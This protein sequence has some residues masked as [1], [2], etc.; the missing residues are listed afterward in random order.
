VAVIAVVAVVGGVVGWTQ[1]TDDRTTVVAG[2]G[3]DGDAPTPLTAQLLPSDTVGATLESVFGLPTPGEEPRPF[4]TRRMVQLW[5]RGGTP[6]FGIETGGLVSAVAGSDDHSEH[7]HLPGWV[8]ATYTERADGARQLVLNAGTRAVG[9]ASRELSRDQLLA[10]APAVAPRTTGLGADV[11]PGALPNDYEPLGEAETPTA[12]PLRLSYAKRTDPLRSLTVLY[13]S[14]TALGQ[15]YDRLLDP[16][17]ATEPIGEIPGDVRDERIRATVRFMA[18]DGVEVEVDVSASAP[19]NVALALAVARSFRPVDAE[20]WQRALA[21]I[22]PPD[23]ASVGEAA[24]T[25]AATAVPL[26]TGAGPTTTSAPAP[27]VELGSVL[28]RLTLPDGFSPFGEV[29]T[30]GAAGQALVHQSQTF[31][32]TDGRYLVVAVL[33]GRTAQ[34]L[35]ELDAP[36]PA[37]VQDLATAIGP[38]VRIDLGAVAPDT[39]QLGR[40]TGPATAVTMT[41]HGVSE[42]VL[43]DLLAAATA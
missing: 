25:T 14:E 43:T 34:Q 42:A 35:L 31:R 24:S 13:R 17:T 20:T 41:G 8:D 2:P 7:L 39:V 29:R 21:T 26:D 10:L 15:Q 22:P 12:R 33:G 37:A 18:L 5:A 32:S 19:E 11:A 6:V 36:D 1:R 23:D 27:P 28:A 9:L 40:A 3:P 30:I 4:D 16:P 38:V